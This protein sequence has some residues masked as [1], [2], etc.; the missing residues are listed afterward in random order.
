MPT[1]IN[2]S[3]YNNNIWHGLQLQISYK[4]AT[5]VFLGNI[6]TKNKNKKGTVETISRKKKKKKKKVFSEKANK[7]VSTNNSEILGGSR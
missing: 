1:N 7:I 3:I 6:S 2:L 4:W 5:N